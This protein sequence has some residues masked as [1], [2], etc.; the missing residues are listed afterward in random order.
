MFDRNLCA[1]KTDEEL[2]KRALEKKG[3]YACLVEK[4]APKLKKYISRFTG[5]ANEAID[6][7]LQNAFIKAYINLN[8]FDQSLKFSSWIYRI[9][10]NEAISYLRANKNKTA[11]IYFED[12][13]GNIYEKIA[14]DIDLTIE[15]RKTINKEQ[16][17]KVLSRMDSKYR[18]IIVLRFL[19]EKDYGEISDILKMPMGTVATMVSRAK[20][21][22]K[23]VAIKTN[24]NFEPL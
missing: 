16:I 9:A 4:Y 12:E 7:I 10:H 17:K 14:S 2:A 8:D 23:E 20:K 22:F 6:D 24:I 5:L 13:E 11:S 18:E 19:E 15:A 21:H 3:F 1:G